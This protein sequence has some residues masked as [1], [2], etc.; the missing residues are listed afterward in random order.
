MLQIS[1]KNDSDQQLLA[2]LRARGASIITILSSKLTALMIQL[3]RYVVTE[4]LQ[5]QVLAQRKGILAGSVR[6]IPAVIN[7]DRI[8]AGVEAGG[9]PAFYGRIQ[10]F[11]APGPFEIIATRARAL[12]F[13]VDG[14]KVVV[15]KVTHPG[16]RARPFMS[17]S[18]AENAE[19]IQTQLRA[20]M[21]AELK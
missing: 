5:G 1:F 18:L 21:E 8:E 3:Q 7:G 6:A 11:G 13:I 20:A 9:G 17:T 19:M 4:K 16:L 14:R 12:S 15:A 10:E 2:G